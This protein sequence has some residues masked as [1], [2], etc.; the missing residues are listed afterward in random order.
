MS[1]VVYWENAVQDMLTKQLSGQT[2]IP[3]WN[4]ANE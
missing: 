1:K 3:C 4:H 2:V